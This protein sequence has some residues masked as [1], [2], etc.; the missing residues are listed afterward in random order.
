MSD[1][2]SIAMISYLD[3]LAHLFWMDAYQALTATEPDW[4]RYDY[5]AFKAEAVERSAMYFR[6]IDPGLPEARK[7]QHPSSY[8]E[9]GADARKMVEKRRQDTIDM[10]AKAE[11]D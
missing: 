11:V 3:S 9:G 8:F 5:C 4:S 7:R 6:R 1:D 10:R 2:S